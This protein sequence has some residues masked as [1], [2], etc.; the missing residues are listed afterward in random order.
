MCVDGFSA[1]RQLSY[2]CGCCEVIIIRICSSSHNFY[3]FG[4]YRNK[5][6]LNR[7]LDCLLTAMTKVHSVYRKASFLFFG[8]GHQLRRS[9]LPA[10]VRLWNLLPLGV[11]S[12]GTLSSFTALNLCLLRP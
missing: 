12:G 1:Y 2:E 4:V 7:I 6:I 8:V 11:F 5:D 9:F 10:A 3:V